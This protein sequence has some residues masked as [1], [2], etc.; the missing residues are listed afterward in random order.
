MNQ[1]LSS[2][3]A[4]NYLTVSQHSRHLLGGPVPQDNSQN[5]QFCIRA[6]C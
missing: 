6:I 1:I 5:M 3:D 2:S 4:I